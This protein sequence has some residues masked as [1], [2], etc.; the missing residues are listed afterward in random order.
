MRLRIITGKYGG[1]FI[2]APATNDTRPTTEKNRG[3]IYNILSNMIDFEEI[4]GADL[5]AGSGAL[6]FEMISRGATLVHFVEKSAKVTRNLEKNIEVLKAELHSAVHLRGCTE[7]IRGYSGNPLSLIV[8]DPPFFQYDIYQVFSAVKE[9]KV[10]APGGIFLVERS[11][12]TAEKDQVHFGF[13]PYRRM[14]DSL[15]YI[16]HNEA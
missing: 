12:Q 10:L 8:A 11:V 1:R 13:E 7:F 2:E 6:G 3:A 5:Y 16:Y 9:H 14:G 15:I 4:T